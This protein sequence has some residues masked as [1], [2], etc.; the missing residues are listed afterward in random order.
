[1]SLLRP[2]GVRSVCPSN[3]IANVIEYVRYTL[4]LVVINSRA[5]PLLQT[6][7]GRRPEAD[8]VSQPAPGSRGRVDQ[9]LK[10]RELLGSRFTF[11][12]LFLLVRIGCGDNNRIRS[13]GHGVL[14][15]SGVDQRA[16]S[17]VT[18]DQ[19]HQPVRFTRPTGPT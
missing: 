15:C 3:V 16:G 1:M 19:E 10:L 6:V 7:Q 8:R 12:H 9:A 17:L 2:R 18:G 4:K 13:D 11:T 5:A 14:P